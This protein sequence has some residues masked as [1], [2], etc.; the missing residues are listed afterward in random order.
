MIWRAQVHRTHREVISVLGDRDRW[1]CS[2]YRRYRSTAGLEV[3]A[4]VAGMI[5][6][7][8]SIDDMDLLRHGAMG[9]SF[10]GVHAPSTFGGWHKATFTL[11]HDA[12]L[13][14]MPSWAGTGGIST[15]SRTSD[16]SA[17]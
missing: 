6:S 11:G 12:D 9:Q 13:L 2:R 8:D 3:P 16:C 1:L 14:M 17:V 7:A 5:A 4:L 10:T 15:S